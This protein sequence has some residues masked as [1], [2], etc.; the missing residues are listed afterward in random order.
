VA[1]SALDEARFGIRTARAHGVTAETL[2]HVLAFCHQH[3]VRLLIARSQRADIET[4]RSAQAAR[5]RLMDVLMYWVADLTTPAPVFDSPCVVRPLRRGEADAVR[6]TALNA[7]RGYFGHYH[8]DPRLDNRLCDE[9]YADWVY[10][11]CSGDSPD[12][13][14]VADVDG[15][16]A[17]FA[18]ARVVNGEGLALLS[19]VDPSL[20]RRGIYRSLHAGRM[21]WCRSQGADR[22]WSPTLAANVT[23]QRAYVQAGLVYSHACYTFH[24]W[25]DEDD[26][27]GFDEHLSGDRRP[28]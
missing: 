23:T 2:P 6:Q 25:F 16:I 28:A 4:L 9:A 13:V 5:L 1:L 18:S 15:H 19:G 27:A 24:R 8:A 20:R 22:M 10:R 12:G 26:R 21:Q 3:D 17:G 14:I 11:S 7:F